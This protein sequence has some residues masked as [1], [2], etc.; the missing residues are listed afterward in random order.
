M[1][2]FDVKQPQISVIERELELIETAFEKSIKSVV[3]HFNEYTNN[4]FSLSLQEQEVLDSNFA[5]FKTSY[6]QSL[7]TSLTIAQKAY[8]TGRF[9][10]SR[11]SYNNASMNHFKHDLLHH[12]PSAANVWILDGL[13]IEKQIGGIKKLVGVSGEDGF[14][15][16]V[17]NSAS[18]LNLGAENPWL[19]KMD[20]IEDFLGIKDN[21]AAVYHPGIRQ[22]FALHQLAKL[23]PGKQSPEQVKVHIESSGAITNSIAIE[24]VVAYSEK[25]GIQDGVILAID[26]SWA[27]GY[28]VARE[29]TGFGINRQT[30]Q[31]THKNFWI[32]KCLPVPTLKNKSLFLK[33]IINRLQEGSLAGLFFEPDMIGDLGMINADETLIREVVKVC[34]ENQI[35]IIL[36]CVQQMGRTG[37]YWGDF[38]GRLFSEVSLLVVTAG[39]SASNGQPLSFVLLPDVIANAA[40]P[41]TQLTTNQMNGPLLRTLLVSEVLKDEKVQMLIKE[42]STTVERIAEQYGFSVG[43]MGLRGKFLNR[44]IF[45]GD[46]EQVKLAQ[47]ALLVEDGV[48]V[49][50][51]PQTIRYQPMLLEFS[52][53]NALTAEIIFRRIEQVKKGNIS[54]E[55]DDIYK[56]M[57]K[58]SSGL[59]RID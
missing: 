53:T 51:F 13:I 17:L 7:Q 34:Q 58:L 18:S 3:D 35:P 4:I 9:N 29:A 57:Q 24:S 42:K 5:I 8:E 26:G 6:I 54:K 31:R 38:V 11:I 1:K 56:K 40:Y 12:F 20:Q 19:I 2:Y 25:K 30:L 52:E 50:A 23:Y 14:V 45:M 44:G 46:N 37:S 39:K 15:L 48:L 49:G 21:M 32:E 43:E 22:S 28:G 41:L 59:A 16:D 33:T 47:I 10:K 27:G 55:V 36:D